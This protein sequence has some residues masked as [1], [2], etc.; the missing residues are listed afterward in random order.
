MID[1]RSVFRLVEGGTP[2]VRLRHCGR[3]GRWR[4]RT[5]FHLRR[6][7]VDSCQT[8]CK[9]CT[10]A[11]VD[12]AYDPAKARSYRQRTIGTPATELPPAAVQRLRSRIGDPE[13]PHGCMPWLG[14]LSSDGY[15][16]WSFRTH[17]RSAHRDLMALHLQRSL[18]SSEHVD[19]HCRRT[20]CV[21]VQHFSIVT[22]E[23]NTRRKSLTDAEHWSLPRSTAI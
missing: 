20:G 10:V 23:E 21:N 12:H 22:S 15:A 3:C 17:S 9:T 5:D 18:S 2:L 19:H 7:S 1:A 11:M 8:Y 16:R 4:A 14:R 13:G 6:G